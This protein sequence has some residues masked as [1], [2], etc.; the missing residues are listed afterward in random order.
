MSKTFKPY[1]IVTTKL[2]AQKVQRTLSK[3]ELKQ[4]CADLNALEP[5]KAAIAFC[6]IYEH[7][8]DQVSSAPVFGRGQKEL[9]YKGIRGSTTGGDC[10]TSRSVTFNVNDLPDYLRLILYEY[11]TLDKQVSQD[12]EGRGLDKF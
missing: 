10:R 12:R 3:E 11:L 8:K 4:M 9:P 6:L 7:G 5:S 1:E 2:K